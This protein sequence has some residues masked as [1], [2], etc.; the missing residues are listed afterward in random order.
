MAQPTNGYR[1]FFWTMVAAGLAALVAVAGAMI[2]TNAA[3]SVL[4]ERSNAQSG[5]N[6][7]I[8]QE[9]QER[10]AG[11]YTKDDAAEDFA[12]VRQRIV[13]LESDVAALREF[14][15][16]IEAKSHPTRAIP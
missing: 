1:K 16:A 3:V 8:R 4:N 14:R 9:L 7:S 2:A 13:R 6:E 15:A 12:N 11:R 5:I 10:T